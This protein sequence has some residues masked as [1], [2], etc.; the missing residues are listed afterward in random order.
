METYST[1][2]TVEIDLT[3]KISKKDFS[4]VEVTHKAVQTS[5]NKKYSSVGKFTITSINDLKQIKEA[6][7][8]KQKIKAYN[9]KQKQSI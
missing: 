8:L 1:L 6:Q 4:L 3:Y 5:D 7:G 9:Y 2:L